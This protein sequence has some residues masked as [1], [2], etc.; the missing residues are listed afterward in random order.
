MRAKGVHGKAA[1]TRVSYLAGADWRE[2]VRV[3]FGLDPEATVPAS[4]MTAISRALVG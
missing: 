3:A 1:Q 2:V 4:F